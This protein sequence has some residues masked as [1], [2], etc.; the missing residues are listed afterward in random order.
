MS[1]PPD[2]NRL[3]QPSRIAQVDF[4]K[5][6]KAATPSS[7]I[8]EGLTHVSDDR[9]HNLA[10]RTCGSRDATPLISQSHSGTHSQHIKPH[11]SS[12]TD[13][14]KTPTLVPAAVASYGEVS[15]I[16]R[17]DGLRDSSGSGA[18]DSSGSAHRRHF[19]D[20]MG[21]AARLPRLLDSPKYQPSQVVA[22]AESS[23]GALDRQ[24]TL[25]ITDLG[26]ILRTQGQQ[27]AE[28]LGY[29][30]S[31]YSKTPSSSFVDKLQHRIQA[32]MDDLEFDIVKH[33]DKHGALAGPIQQ[34]S[35]PQLA[36][37]FR[38][39]GGA[40]SHAQV[41]HALMSFH[42]GQSDRQVEEAL[43]APNSTSNKP[44][45]WGT[46]GRNPTDY[47]PVPPNQPLIGYQT[48]RQHETFLQE[49]TSAEGKLRLI[50]TG[51]WW[52]NPGTMLF[53]FC[54]RHNQRYIISYHELGQTSRQ[55]TM[56]MLYDIVLERNAANLRLLAHAFRMLR[57]RKAWLRR[58]WMSANAQRIEKLD[59]FPPHE[60]E[61]R[62]SVLS[63]IMMP[64]R[65]DKL[66]VTILFN[67]VGEQFHNTSEATALRRLVFARGYRHPFEELAK[68]YFD[69]ASGENTLKEESDVV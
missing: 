32:S 35:D 23:K 30:F 64:T 57:G 29:D 21:E 48:V 15:C 10:I 69:V 53:Q 9:A 47:E 20:H 22:A 65:D 11:A 16:S 62:T 67:A 46:I 3:W 8:V 42:Q 61:R 38:A 27:L 6:A 39:S 68:V 18:V 19:P 43:C 50:L 55:K 44:E 54:R 33:S 66:S 37:A 56:P 2:G 13:Y 4:N 1:K 60:Q 51:P 41:A 28:K 59:G 49:V 31:R 12:L 45:A 52:E 24:V 40:T 58:S 25:S 5:L 14:G 7:S 36:Q 34:P 17:N 26:L 63:K